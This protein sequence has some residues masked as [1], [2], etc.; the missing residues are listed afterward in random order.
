MLRTLPIQSWPWWVKEGAL[1]C[2]ECTEMQ[3][4]LYLVSALFGFLCQR[5]GWGEANSHA[6]W[7]RPF[8]ALG[9]CGRML[10]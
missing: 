1:K 7:Q 6:G 5:Q 8:D 3:N 4:V 9:T 2:A 10:P